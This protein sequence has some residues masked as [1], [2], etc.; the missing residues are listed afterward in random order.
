M[1]PRIMIYTTEVDT[2]IT[3]IG[4]RSIITKQK[5]TDACNQ[6]T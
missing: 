1:E 5:S 6:R 4:H 2:K 3:T